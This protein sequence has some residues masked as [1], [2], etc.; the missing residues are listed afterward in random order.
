MTEVTADAVAASL[1]GSMEGLEGQPRDAA[2]T[3]YRLVAGGTPVD[4]EQI[5][6]AVG[7]R[8]GGRRQDARR[9]A[10][11]PSRRPRSSGRHLGSRTAGDT[12]PL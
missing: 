5:A 6:E 2:L 4:E 11:D 12:A 7:A 1:A 9:V 3:I 8:S 10:G